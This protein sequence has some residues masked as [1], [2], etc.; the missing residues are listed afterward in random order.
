M[1]DKTIWQYWFKL[2]AL[3]SSCR[4]NNQ[5]YR[6]QHDRH[7]WFK[8]LSIYINFTNYTEHKY[9]I[10]Q[11]LRNRVK[12]IQCNKTFNKYMYINSLIP[13]TVSPR[14]H[15]RYIG[16]DTPKMIGRV[17]SFEVLLCKGCLQ[18]RLKK[19]YLSNK[20]FQIYCRPFSLHLKSKVQIFK[21]HKRKMFESERKDSFYF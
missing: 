17:S 10:K 18:F 20:M 9:L 1:K 21:G 14:M 13:I 11:R 3:R 12:L 15:R 7:P 4:F 6:G 2:W 5:A 8:K 19:Q 16:I